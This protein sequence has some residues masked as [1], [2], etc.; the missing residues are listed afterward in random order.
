MSLR[1][2][3]HRLRPFMAV[4]MAGTVLATATACSQMEDR[5][6]GASAGEDTPAAQA[7]ATPKTM[8]KATREAPPQ[9][10][11]TKFKSPKGLVDN[12]RLFEEPVSDPIA[13]IRRI[14]VAVQDLRDDFDN[15]IPAMAGLIVSESE[16]AQV[17]ED[18][19][20]SGEI[21]YTDITPPRSGRLPRQ[22][23]EPA[24]R[25]RE[26]RPDRQ[27]GAIAPPQ[28]MTTQPRTSDAGQRDVARESIPPRRDIEKTPP[29]KAE[30]PKVAKKPEPA[31]QPAKK[32]EK[33]EPKY[34][35]PHVINVRIGSYPD[36]TR[37]VLDM[38]EPAPYHVDLDNDEKLL[39]LEVKNAG[40]D[41]KQSYSFKNS[42]LLSSFTA[43]EEGA[44]GSRLLLAL[45]QPVKILKKFALK[46]DGPRKDRIV[47]DIAPE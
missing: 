23:L 33:P 12:R 34:S 38:S 45:K 39:V 27:P 4:L 10:T 3:K 15:A 6:K 17:L 40:W 35:T 7:E 44:N 47:L 21:R 43:Q 9:S 2:G 30:Q 18:L 31:P 16:L 46:A 19:K 36:K 42:Q 26:S 29:P 25:D 28:A 37:I 20:R 8:P 24:M 1:P 32:A 11:G 14:E 13:R 5:F 41:A 22:P